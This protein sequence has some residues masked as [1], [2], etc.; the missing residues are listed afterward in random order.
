MNVYAPDD[1]L[2]S[3]GALKV[4]SAAAKPLCRGQITT[5]ADDGRFESAV[6]GGSAGLPRAKDGD[7]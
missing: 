7:E 5:E 6:G 4:P 2:R 3:G 1:V